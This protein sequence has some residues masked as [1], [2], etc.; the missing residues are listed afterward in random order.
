MLHCIICRYNTDQLH[1]WNY[2]CL[3][4]S[5]SRY[6]KILRTVGSVPGLAQGWPASNQNHHDAC[7]VNRGQTT[8]QQFCFEIFQ[9]SQTSQTRKGGRNCWSSFLSINKIAAQFLTSVLF[10]NS[11]G[12]SSS[13]S[14]VTSQDSELRQVLVEELIIKE[15]VNLFIYIFMVYHQHSSSDFSYSVHYKCKNIQGY[16]LTLYLPLDL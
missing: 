3:A 9:T 13:R 15:I 10:M 1:D 2:N 11:I 12:P 14:E 4:V 5:V 6:K 7:F 8:T 16:S